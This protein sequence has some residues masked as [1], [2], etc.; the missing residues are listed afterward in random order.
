MSDQLAV[1]EAINEARAC[2]L[3]VVKIDAGRRAL[4]GVIE[5]AY[6]RLEE[7]RDA[8]KLGDVAP[9]LSAL[10]EALDLL[11]TDEARLI[12]ED[13]G[14]LDEAIRLISRGQHLLAELDITGDDPPQ[15]RGGS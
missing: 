8:L 1:Q 15:P 5:S 7:A 10:A 9:T 12:A 14:A 4:E 2:L 11:R 6:D 3:N 13:V